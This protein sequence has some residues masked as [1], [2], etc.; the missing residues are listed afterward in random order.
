MWQILSSDYDT[1][2]SYYGVKKACEKIHIQLDL[3][4]Y[5]VAVV[6][7]STSP[8]SS[9]LVRA[10]VYSIANK[11]LLKQEEHRTIEANATGNA[12]KL[13]LS[14][15]IA[16]DVAFVRL[17]LLDGTGKLVSDN[18]YWLASD[19]AT[20]RQLTK[21]PKSNLTVTASG[22]RKGD[23]V[24]LRVHLHNSGTTAAVATK[25]ILTN[26]TDGSRILPAYYGDN[27]ISLL[28]GEVR[29]VEI[30]APSAATQGQP[31]INIRGWNTA[32]TTIPV[33]LHR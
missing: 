18:F 23:S 1:Q 29:D 21:L 4:D 3:S 5:T 9:M 11:L 24:V 13:E 27:Y 12:F 30:E 2:G 16:N 20:Y 6:N 14:P 17:E 25:L 7:N 28:P 8:L 10:T 26:A 31:Q 33:T 15:L 32:A 19:S 22:V